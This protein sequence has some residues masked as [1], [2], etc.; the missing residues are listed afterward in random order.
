MIGIR[1]NACGRTYV[2]LAGII[3]AFIGSGFLKKRESL[4]SVLAF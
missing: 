2:G 1:Y 3:L 4:S